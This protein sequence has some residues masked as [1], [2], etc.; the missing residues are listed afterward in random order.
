MFAFLADPGNHWR[1][2]R[3][4]IEVI[5]VDSDGHGY[6]RGTVLL[7]GPLGVRRR[8]RTAVV[9]VTPSRRLSGVASIGGRT[10][11]EV[12]WSLAPAAGAATWVVLSADMLRLSRLDAILLAAGGR[13]WMRRLFSEVLVALGELAPAAAAAPAAASARAETITR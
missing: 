7:R 12:T 11:A 13:A 5:A 1:L 9:E 3:E 4:R 6:M 10:R 2:A 8:A